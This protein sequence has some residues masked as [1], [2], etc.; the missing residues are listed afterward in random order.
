MIRKR[1]IPVLML[2]MLMTFVSSDQVFGQIHNNNDV[3]YTRI[4]DKKR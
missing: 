3:Y 4:R 1:T 2:T